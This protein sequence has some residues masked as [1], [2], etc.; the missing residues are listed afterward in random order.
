MSTASFYKVIPKK[1]AELPAMIVLFIVALIGFAFHYDFFGW[2][3]GF[4]WFGFALP[5]L[6]WI[7][8]KRKGE[9]FVR[10]DENGI[11]WREHFF[12]NYT[13]IPWQYV[14]RIDYLVYEINFMLK[15]TAQ[16]VC[17]ATSGLSEEE[18]EQLKQEISEIIK[19]RIEAGQ[20]GV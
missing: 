13:Y 1:K 12:S 7:Y 17:F 18:T 4:I 8:Q 9:Y 6:M 20:H 19:K 11:A 14:Q 5:L 3:G 16:V 10:V 15:E 2:T